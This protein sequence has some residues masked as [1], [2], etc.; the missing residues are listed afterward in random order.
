VLGGA[1][2]AKAKEHA[3]RA[4]RDVAAE[5]L[6]I[7][8][9]RATQTG[10]AFP[11]DNAWQREFEGSFV[12]EETPDQLRAID[13][14]KHDLESPKPMDRLICGDVG[15]GKTEVAIRPPPCSRS[16]T[17]IISANAW[18]TIRCAW[19]CSLASAARSSRGR[20]FRP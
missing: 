2:W 3:E 11:P 20:R 4:V 10:H 18:R 14:A 1:R 8:A 7:Q 6:Q 5:L 13:A 16:S 19:K 12:Y 9:A 15:F 17:T